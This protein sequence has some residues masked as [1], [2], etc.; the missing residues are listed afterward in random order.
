MSGIF[1]FLLLLFLS[2]DVADDFFPCF[3]F[4]VVVVVVVVFFFCSYGVMLRRKEKER[5]A[6]AMQ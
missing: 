5:V 4:V 6:K 2:F 3:I 1:I